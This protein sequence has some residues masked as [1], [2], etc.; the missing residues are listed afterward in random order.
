[1]VKQNDH[2]GSMTRD[3]QRPID[4][5]IQFGL[6]PLFFLTAFFAAL[7]MT[8]MAGYTPLSY[9]DQL[10]YDLTGR[11]SPAAAARD[12]RMIGYAGLSFVLAVATVLSMVRKAKPGDAKED[13]ADD[14]DPISLAPSDNKH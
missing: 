4:E 7:V 13:D 2:D 6:V 8:A 1:M 12:W 10:L 14:R 11:R 9:A 3:Q 5:P